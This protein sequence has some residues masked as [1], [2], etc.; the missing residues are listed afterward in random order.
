MSTG[1]QVIEIYGSIDSVYTAYIYSI[2]WCQHGQGHS[3][4]SFA[5]CS[6]FSGA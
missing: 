1:A 5:K 3:D 4:G 2:L 6:S